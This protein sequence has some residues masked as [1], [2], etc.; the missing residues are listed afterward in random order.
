MGKWVP[1]EIFCPGP[2][3]ERDAPASLQMIG[4]SGLHIVCYADVAAEGELKR[5]RR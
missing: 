4:E 1:R 2:G 3:K 5:K